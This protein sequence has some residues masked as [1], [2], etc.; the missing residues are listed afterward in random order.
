LSVVSSNVVPQQPNNAYIKFKGNT[1]DADFEFTATVG[2]F[3]VPI[4]DGSL[5]SF[6]K[7]LVFSVEKQNFTR[8]KIS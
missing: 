2:T 8:R 3:A 6:V 7:S 1:K 5:M 4:G